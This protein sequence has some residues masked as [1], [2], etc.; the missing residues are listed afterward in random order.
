[1][2]AEVWKPLK[3]VRCR[4]C[5]RLSN[6]WRAISTGVCAHCWDRLRSAGEN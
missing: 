6:H 5:G 4:A 3:Y 2:P 1:M